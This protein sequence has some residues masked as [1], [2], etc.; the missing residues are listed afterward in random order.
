MVRK[1][2]LQYSRSLYH[3]VV[4]LNIIIR[5]NLFYVNL[6]NWE[7]NTPSHSPKALGT[8]LKILERTGPS[9]GI[10]HK[11]A[12]HERSPRAP[13]FQETLH[14]ERCAREAA[15]DLAKTFTC[16]RMRTTLRF[17]VLGEVKGKSTPI[18][19]Q[20]PEGRE[21]EV[22]S[23]ASRHTMSHRDLCAEEMDTIKR[24]RTPTAVLTANGEVQN[25]EEAQMF[26]YDLNQFVTVQLLEATPAVLSLC[27]LC[28]DNGYSYEWVSQRSRATID[29]KQENYYLQNGQFR[30]RLFT[31]TGSDSSCTTPSPES[32][33]PDESQ[34]SGNR[35]ASCSSRDSVS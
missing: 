31:N 18:A 30:P 23:G 11:C 14:Q 35:V 32:L 19:S 10:I 7:Q 20:R 34:A 1:D 33:E 21:F 27:K 9:R 8:K 2:Q 15:W 29:P 28:K 5:E 25:H 26:V 13:E 17:H 12:P 16:S 6:E 22:D 24:S 3:C 4:Y